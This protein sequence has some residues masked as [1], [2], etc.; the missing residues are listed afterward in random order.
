MIQK[1]DSHPCPRKYLEVQYKVAKIVLEASDF[2]S[3]A[4]L[5]LETITNGLGWSAGSLWIVEESRL[6]LTRIAEYSPDLPSLGHKNWSQLKRFYSGQGLP[7]KVWMSGEPKWITDLTLNNDFPRAD[8]AAM[9]GL[10]TVC[11][12][13]FLLDGKVIGLFEYFH[14]NTLDPDSDMLDTL[15]VVGTMIGQLLQRRRDEVTLLRTHAKLQQAYKREKKIAS[16]FQK[17]LWPETQQILLGYDIAFSYKSAHAD[18]DVG[19][20]FFNLFD[21]NPDHVAVVI[22]D[23]GGKGLKAAITAAWLQ[24]SL[25]ALTIRAK[26][27]PSS[28][29][30]DLQQILASLNVDCLTTVFLAILEK[31]SG[32]ISY[33]SAGHE[34]AVV[35]R[36]KSGTCEQLKFGQPALVG[37][38]VEPY[39]CHETT[40][41]SG[42]TLFLYTD[43]LSEAGTSRSQMLGQSGI[44]DLL[45]YCRGKTS[46]QILK[47]FCHAASSIS[48]GSLKDDIAMIALRRLQESETT[49]PFIEVSCSEDQTFD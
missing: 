34:P 17:A 24:H 31:A 4:D 19:G 26:A 29:L 3:V 22:G 23:V 20:D 27:D 8:E 38:Q 6:C 10:H 30:D 45:A 21:I 28:A 18:A 5:V 1:E 48:H 42:D 46:A 35:W 2:R 43:G 41:L 40:L 39:V 11:G 13:P 16:Q 9:V 36:A 33:S 44:M 14:K 49:S 7:G 25:M 12:A 32:R 15:V 47:F 37:L